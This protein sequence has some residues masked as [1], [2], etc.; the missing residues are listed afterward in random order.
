MR[1]GR[2]VAFELSVRNADKGCLPKELVLARVQQ[3]VKEGSPPVVC[4]DAPLYVAKARLL[5]NTTFV[6]GKRPRV[7]PQTPAHNVC[8]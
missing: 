4:T 3:F 7:P 6:V 1:P 8:A 2:E 5:P